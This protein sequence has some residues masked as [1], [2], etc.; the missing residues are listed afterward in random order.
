[1]MLSFPVR[2]VSAAILA[3]ASLCRA[4]GSAAQITSVVKP[5][6]DIVP[7]CAFHCTRSFVQ[8]DYPGN[9]CSR[10]S[11]INCLCRTNTTSGLTLGEGALRCIYSFCVQQIRPS[12]SAYSICDSV[13]GALPK[14]HATIT[15]TIP[16]IN[17]P[18]ATE[19]TGGAGR[20]F[21]SSSN[22]T[23]T[24]TTTV[25]VSTSTTVISSQS[26]TTKCSHSVPSTP[27][28]ATHGKPTQ[29]PES[30]NTLNSAAVIGISVASGIS[31]AFIIGVLV[32]FCCRRVRRTHQNRQDPGF[33]EIGGFMTEPPE[34]CVPPTRRPTPGSQSCPITTNKGLTGRRAMSPFR[35]VAQNPAVVVTKPDYDRSPGYNSLGRI[36]LAIS[37]ESEHDGSSRSQETPRTLSDLL[38][39][40][41]DLYPEPL[42]L[43]QQTN[44]P[45]HSGETP[46]EDDARR[47]RSIFG[48]S[49]GT[50]PSG[51]SSKE[52]GNM[53]FNR[54]RMIGLPPNPR[55]MKQGFS[56]G[57]PSARS[58]GQ[59]RIPTY[60]TGGIPGYGAG[61][62]NP[63][64]PVSPP[65]RANIK[66]WQDPH[67]VGY[68]SDLNRPLPRLPSPAASY[69]PPGSS[70]TR[71]E[72]GDIS[73]SHQPR[74]YARNS[75]VFRPLT[76]VTEVR[77]PGNN[78]REK[79]RHDYF[80]RPP[81]RYPAVHPVNEIVSRPRIVRQ[82]DIKRVQIRRGK[83]QPKELQVPYSP[84]DY[85]LEHSRGQRRM[86][87]GA[88]PAVLNAAQRG[89]PPEHSLTPSRRG[90]DLILRVD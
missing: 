4:D 54:M 32:F 80:N 74:G 9:A 77:A 79:T 13:R 58:P 82:D 34:F 83:P 49:S 44:T 5:L 31:F 3:L 12:L 27:T 63:T 62:S 72:P 17:P 48:P 84:E 22:T 45:P 57:P 35:T 42:R 51:S 21:P 64:S 6:R 87:S 30:S 14:T 40:K 2:Y 24:Q 26:N 59:R 53:R 39:D 85:W 88:N 66:H 47:R 55:A 15:A 46:L 69:Q 25:P 11:D 33:F 10:G 71:L 65:D 90:G 60:A 67:G 28:T 86:Y 20:T 75:G 61:C 19:K 1:M 52:Y 81:S 68:R 70:E 23:G 18:A 73:N 76:P 56:G 29:T 38:P 50:N 16:F 41:P 36:G 7:D 89:S 43:S 8:S 78:A 37:S